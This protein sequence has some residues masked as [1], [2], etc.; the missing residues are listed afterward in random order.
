MG[1]PCSPT[2]PAPVPRLVEDHVG[3][4]LRVELGAVGGRARPTRQAQPPR[5]C[6]AFEKR[7]PPRPLAGPRRP[8]RRRPRET[9]GPTAG[10]ADPRRC[11]PRVARSSSKP[12]PGGCRPA[13]AGSGRRWS[14]HA[15][16]AVTRP[17]PRPGRQTP[18]PRR[19]VRPRPPARLTGQP[20]GLG[21]E[22]GLVLLRR[23]DRVRFTAGRGEQKAHGQPAERRTAPPDA[24]R[25]PRGT[26]APV[27]VCNFASRTSLRGRLTAPPRLST[28]ARRRR[29]VS[30]SHSR[31]EH[32]HREEGIAPPAAPRGRPVRVAAA[33]TCS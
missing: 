6:V 4:P 32:R 31:P 28:M 27:C 13:A 25:C 1:T 33:S 12:A 7:Q 23:S 17:R 5:R 22:R 14:A 29:G 15:R 20:C 2:P 3:A 16:P 24:T 30:A 9:V 19:P 11:T 21:R 18:M 26:A 10:A 8:C